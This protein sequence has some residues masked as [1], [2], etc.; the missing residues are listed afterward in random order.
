[1]SVVRKIGLQAEVKFWC[2]LFVYQLPV[3]LLKQSE[4]PN[5]YKN[6]IKSVINYMHRYESLVFIRH[7]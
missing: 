3:L 1:M 5:F 2:T 7:R 4:K 6:E